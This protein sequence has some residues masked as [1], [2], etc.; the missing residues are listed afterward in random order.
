MGLFGCP[1]FFLLK[2]LR[3][4]GAHSLVLTRTL[5]CA[6]RLIPNSLS[7]AFSRLSAYHKK[8]TLSGGLYWWAL[9]GS[10][11]RPS[12][13]KRD[14]LPAELSAHPVFVKFLY[15]LKFQKSSLFFIKLSLFYIFSANSIS[16]NYKYRYRM[17]LI[18]INKDFLFQIIR[19]ILK[20]Q[21]FF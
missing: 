9:R 7:R 14:A 6:F 4:I 21:E 20:L 8:T 12:R 2:K 11:S 5:P 15:T 10:N 13:C 1:S 3:S 16:Y 19:L 18:I 17:L